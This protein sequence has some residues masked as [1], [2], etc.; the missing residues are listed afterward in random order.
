MHSCGQTPFQVKFYQYCGSLFAVRQNEIYTVDKDFK[1]K[2]VVKISCDQ[3]L[4]HLFYSGGI[5]LLQIRGKL[6]GFIVNMQTLKVTKVKLYGK[7]IPIQLNSYGIQLSTQY[8]SQFIGIDQLNELNKSQVSYFSQLMK[9]SIYQKL[10][11]TCCQK[12]ISSLSISKQNSLLRELQLSQEQSYYKENTLSLQELAFVTPITNSQQQI[13]LTL[14]NNAIYVID[15]QIQVLQQYYIDFQFYIGLTRKHQFYSTTIQFGFQYQTIYNNGQIYLIYFDQLYVLSNSNLIKVA[16]VPD[17]NTELECSSS[18]GNIFSLNGTI[19]VQN[20]IKQIFVLIQN[21]FKF[22][23]EV[24][25]N[26]IQFYQ[27]LD[28]VYAV[29]LERVWA[30]RNNFTLEVI[31]D[32]GGDSGSCTNKVAFCGSGCLIVTTNCEERVFALNMIT[33]EFTVFTNNI[34]F[35]QQFNVENIQNII[36][37]GYFGIQIQQNI[38]DEL[39][40]KQFDNNMQRYNNQYWQIQRNQQF[41]QLY[42]QQMNQLY[43]N[44]YQHQFNERMNQQQ[45]QFKEFVIQFHCQRNQLCNSINSLYQVKLQIIIQNFEQMFLNDVQ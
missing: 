39:F 29:G 44:Y 35:N 40:G 41:S 15:Q 26:F 19:Y 7:Q 38:Q 20:N 28:A 21:S 2:E 8:L 10:I 33:G 34:K 11:V 42:D 22:V 13:Y 23:K 37:L 5:L 4:N 31:W 32:N 27:Y 1:F 3:L 6:D 12:I 16:N 18:Y 30:V 45:Q 25:E 24:P 36:E 14:Y 17:F 9:Q 43:D